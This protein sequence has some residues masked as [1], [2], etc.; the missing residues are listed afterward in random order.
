MAMT[1][2]NVVEYV[3]S[4]TDRHAANNSSSSRT[5]RK[6]YSSITSIPGEGTV[7]CA[8]TAR[9]A[10]ETA[11]RA[12]GSAWAADPAPSATAITR[13]LSE[14]SAA[15][16]QSWQPHPRARCAVPATLAPTNVQAAPR[17]E[18]VMTDRSGSN[19]QLGG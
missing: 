8:M 3:S 15:P 12:A 5:S 6:A 14:N 16:H 19:R 9:M 11:M 1:S 10:E 4:S 7:V 18:E 2:D 17:A 13:F